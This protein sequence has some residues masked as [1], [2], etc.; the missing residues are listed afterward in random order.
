M[1]DSDPNI[2]REAFSPLAGVIAFFGG[3]GGLV[4]SLV[5]RQNWLETGRVM[6]IGAGTAYGLGSLSPY[7]FDWLV[8]DV[9]T[10]IRSAFG[11]LCASAFVV[12]LTASALVERVIA[13][14]G[15]TDEH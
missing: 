6:V 4:V 1:S 11:T 14:A 13:Q 3:I 15:R 9:P 5:K 10:E 12:G 7:M 8:G 2:W